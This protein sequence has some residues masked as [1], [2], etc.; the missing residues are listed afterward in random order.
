M[1]NALRADRRLARGTGPR[2]PLGRNQEFDPRRLNQHFA[3][4]VFKHAVFVGDALAKMLQFEPGFDQVPLLESAELAHVLEDAPGE[5]AVAPALLAEFVQRPQ[6]PRPVLGIDAV[7]D[8]DENRTAIIG[9]I[10]G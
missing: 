9:N 7:L 2:P 10:F 1:R 3:D 4:L 6:E 5:C 8:L